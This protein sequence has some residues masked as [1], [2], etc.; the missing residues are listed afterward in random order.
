MKN[1]CVL[2]DNRTGWN[3][4]ARATSIALIELIKQHCNICGI[5][6]NDL[7]LSNV[8]LYHKFLFI[9]IYFFCE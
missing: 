6:Y 3:W 4:G 7:K 1:V 8:V 2:S 5:I 9:K